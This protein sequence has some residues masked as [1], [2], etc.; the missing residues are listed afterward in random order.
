MKIGGQHHW[1]SCRMWHDPDAETLG[2]CSNS[3]TLRNAATDSGIRLNDVY[4]AMR[5]PVLKVMSSEEVLTVG[6]RQGRLFYQLGN[7]IAAVLR[8]WLFKEEHAKVG[9]HLSDAQRRRDRKM[10]AA[11]NQNLNVIAD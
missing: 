3:P 1:P 10:L 5:Q 9:Q 4:T 7:V 8:H 2:Q 11:I 6:N